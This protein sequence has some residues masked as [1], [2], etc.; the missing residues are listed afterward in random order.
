MKKQT[1]KL[2]MVAEPER[3]DR[4]AVNRMA[5]QTACVGPSTSMR[6]AMAQKNSTNIQREMMTLMTKT[7]SDVT[8]SNS[9]KHDTLTNM[10]PQPNTHTVNNHRDDYKVPVTND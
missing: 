8:Q 10:T 9:T 1:D 2:F 4:L 5:R 3:I 6:K 7:A